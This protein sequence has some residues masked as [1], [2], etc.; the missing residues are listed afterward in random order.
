MSR[1]EA[2]DLYDYGIIRCCV[3]EELTRQFDALT[4]KR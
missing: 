4:W 1:V 2:D 3:G